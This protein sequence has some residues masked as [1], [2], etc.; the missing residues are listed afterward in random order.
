LCPAEFDSAFADGVTRMGEFGECG[1]GGHA[2]YCMWLSTYPQYVVSTESL[3]NRCA[4]SVR[5]AY[6]SAGAE[7]QIWRGFVRRD[8]TCVG[9]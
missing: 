9:V 8:E 6:S 5:I 3:A 1:P 2:N 7:R 4:F